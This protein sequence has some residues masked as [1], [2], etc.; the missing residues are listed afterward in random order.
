MKNETIEEVGKQLKGMPGEIFLRILEGEEKTSAEWAKDYKTTKDRIYVVFGKLRKKGYPVF[1]IGGKAGKE[2]GVY[3]IITNSEED[4]FEA[5]TRYKH[6]H[7]M[8]TLETLMM[9]YERQ[10]EVFPETIEQ[11]ESDIKILLEAITHKKKKILI[12]YESA[13]PRGLRE[14]NPAR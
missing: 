6:D 12:S 14:Q 8:P 2:G 3:K 11:V 9:V 13:N 10:I 4:C 5:V 7:Q 1:P